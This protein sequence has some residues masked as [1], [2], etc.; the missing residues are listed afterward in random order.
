MKKDTSIAHAGGKPTERFGFVNPPVYRGSTVVFDTMADLEAA[1]ADRFNKVVYGRIG[2][3]TTMAFEQAMATLEGGYRTVAV[4]SGLA[5]VT[6]SLLAFVSA[7]DHLLMVDSV[8]SPSRNFCDR[9]MS[10]LGVETTYYDPHMAGDIAGLIRDNTK[11]VFTESPGSHSFEVQDIPAIAAAAH[12]RGAVVLHDN[13]WATG[14]FFDA[15]AHGVDVSIHAATKYIVGHSD[16]MLG[17]ITVVNEDHF[18][19]VK[20]AASGLGNCP[21]SEECYLGLRG[22]RTLAIRLRRHQES[23][24]AVAQW[25]A[26]QEEVA[27]VMYPALSDDPGYALWRRDFTGASG[28]LGIVLHRSYPRQAIAAFVD[29][30]ALFGLGASWGGYESLVLPYDLAKVRTA[31]AWTEVSPTLRFHIGLEDPDDLMADLDRAFGRLRAA[32]GE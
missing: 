24:L 6:A 14:L 30:L 22:L 3:P 13:S 26:E 29:G 2:T 16:A 4:S 12:A 23:A 10:R 5:A 28:L 19:A 1:Q 18:R 17:T 20:L 9:I 21:G 8:Y 32:T 31:V 7:G 27:R 15:F 25:L 11:V